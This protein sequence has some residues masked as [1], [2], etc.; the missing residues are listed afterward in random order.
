MITGRT[1]ER[2]RQ[3]AAPRRLEIPAE[4]TQAALLAV[5]YFTGTDFKPARRAPVKE[6]MHWNRWGPP[7]PEVGA[8]R[9]MGAGFAS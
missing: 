6:R 1:G 4:I 7:Q 2:A 9:N 8:H 3:V 5:A